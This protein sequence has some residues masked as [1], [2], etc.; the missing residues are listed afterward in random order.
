MLVVVL[1]H[2][3]IAN[4]G[5]VAV[6]SDAVKMSIWLVA[7][8][9]RSTT[10]DVSIKEF[11]SFGND[12][13]A[14]E[15]LCVKRESITAVSCMVTARPN[16]VVMLWLGVDAT[17]IW[18][19]LTNFVF[20]EAI[21]NRRICPGNLC[22]FT[23]LVFRHLHLWNQ[24]NLVLWEL[25]RPTAST[26]L[27][28]KP[29]ITA[30]RSRSA[31]SVVVKLVVFETTENWIFGR[32]HVTAVGLQQKRKHLHEWMSYDVWNLKINTTE[33]TYNWIRK[34]HFENNCS[35]H[36]MQSTLD[37][38]TDSQNYQLPKTDKVSCGST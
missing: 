32:N 27:I 20:L 9:M 25:W 23:Y 14:V 34:R 8:A 6:W 24:R 4:K 30:E 19:R 2:R 7:M 33:S 29:G 35:G 18:T 17:V 22:L 37:W 36:V 11:K 21:C 31:T 12:D 16:A 15:I 1:S 38:A 28:M 3:A 10:T 26:L 5:I 13:E